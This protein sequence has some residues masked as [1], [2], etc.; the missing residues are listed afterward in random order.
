VVVVRRGGG[1]SWSR[2]WGVVVAVMAVVAVR[3]AVWAAATVHG[4]VDDACD[5]EGMVRWCA[6][7]ARATARWGMQ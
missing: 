1:A 2:C 6:Q 4:D 7:Q 5:D 3:W